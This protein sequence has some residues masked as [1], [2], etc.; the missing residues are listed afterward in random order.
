MNIFE[1]MDMKE[2][3]EFKS[4]LDILKSIW[5]NMKGSK[6]LMGKYDINFFFILAGLNNAFRLGFISSLPQFIWD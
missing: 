2:F 5:V 4:I 3:K 6:E 1:F